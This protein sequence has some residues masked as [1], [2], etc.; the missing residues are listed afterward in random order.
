MVKAVFA[1]S[2][3]PPTNGHL[4]IIKRASGLFENVDVVVSVNPEKKTMFTEEE[5]VQFLQDLIKP[6]KNVSV[7]SYKG[8]I[9]NYA[10]EVGAKVLVRGVRSANDFGYE[11]ELALM[12]Q[13]L[14]PDIETVFLQSKEKYAIVKSSS[15]KQLAQFGGDISRMVP[16]IVEKA[17]REKY[18]N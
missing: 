7:H 18:T 16:E 8:I 17:L 2:F 5:R 3:D 15:I 4:D 11:F 10:K 13:N 12:N 14:N 9:V 6:F 1:G